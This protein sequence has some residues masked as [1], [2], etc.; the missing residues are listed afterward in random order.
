MTGV[1]WFPPHWAEPFYVLKGLLFLVATVLL[2]AHMSR[3]WSQT[4]GRGQRLRYLTLL[5]FSVLFTAASVEQ[6][7]Q[8]A[9]VNYRNLGG[10]VGSGLLI[11]TMCVSLGEY[12][13]S[14]RRP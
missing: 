12:R 9:V 1:P 11:V 2:V 14:R 5:Y 13:R 4:I 3:T 10:L 8:H 6:V 7:Q